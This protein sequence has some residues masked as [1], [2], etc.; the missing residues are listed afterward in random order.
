MHKIK[1]INKIPIKNPKKNA[2]F[3]FIETGAFDSFKTL[4]ALNKY[5]S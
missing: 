1:I 5:L 3:C 2:Y 4:T